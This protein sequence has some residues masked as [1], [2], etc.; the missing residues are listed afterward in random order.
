V[1]KRKEYKSY[2]T[3]HK[4]FT[5][6]YLLNIYILQIMYNKFVE[7][8]I[9]GPTTFSE[10]YGLHSASCGKLRSYMYGKVAAP[11]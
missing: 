1:N 8:Q 2:A 9:P 6:Q 10:K 3:G 5:T 4:L 11:V 7:K